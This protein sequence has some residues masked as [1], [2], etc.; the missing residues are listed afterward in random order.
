MIATIAQVMEVVGAIA[1]GIRVLAQ[2]KQDIAPAL[3]LIDK[4]RAKE[5]ITVA[6]L[7]TIRARNDAL[8]AA[9]QEQ[10]EGGEENA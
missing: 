8:H 10:T 5:P 7:A 6:Y 4:L 1:G 2:A 9:I 3:D